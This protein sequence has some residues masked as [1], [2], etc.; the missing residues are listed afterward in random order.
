MEQ[1][2]LLREDDVPRLTTISGNLD[3]DRITPYIK[4]AQDTQ[5]KRVLGIPLYQKIS[6]DYENDTLVGLYKTIY[7][8]FVVDMLVYYS[9]M[10]IVLFNSFKID[11][12]GV[13][14]YEPDNASPLEMDEVEKVANRY[15]MLGASVE[16]TFKDW[17]GSNKVPEYSGSG[18]CNSSGNTFQMP[19]IL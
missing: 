8:Q 1:L 3:I 10:N 4:M 9:A 16:L 2:I 6:E 14:Q 5:L 19:W 13:F 7:E 18:S 11:N 12:G 15:R 17:L